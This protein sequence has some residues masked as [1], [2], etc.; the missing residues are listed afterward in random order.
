[1]V[2]QNLL[3]NAFKYMGNQAAP[4]IEIG[5]FRTADETVFFVSDNGIGID[6]H[7]HENIFGLFKKLDAKSQGTGIG[8]ALVQRIID[9][10]GGR[11]WVESEGPGTGS[12]FLFTVPEGRDT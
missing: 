9:V 8:L 11:I 10:H 3:E 1:M 2:L 4:R 6:P 5:A 12:R 7:Q